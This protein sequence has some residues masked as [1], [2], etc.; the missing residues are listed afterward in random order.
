[1]NILITSLVYWPDSTGNGPIVTDL[2]RW[3][4]TRGHK[5]T[6]VCSFPHYGRDEIPSEYRGRLTMRDEESGVR[7]IRVYSGSARSDSRLSKVLS[8]TIFTLSVILGGIRAGAA[9]VILAPSPPLSVGISAWALRL[10]KRAPFIYVVQDLFPEAYINL[11]ALKSPTAINFFKAMARFVYRGAAKIVC[12]MDSMVQ[13]VTRYGIPADKVETISNWAD[14]SEIQPC[15]RDNQFAQ[16]HN[17]DG[18]FVVQYAGNI[19]QSQR[20]DL[21]LDC[22]EQ[23][24]DENIKFVIIGSG[25]AKRIL[26][27]SIKEKQL[28]NVLLLDTQPR[29]RLSEVLGACD[30]ALVPLTAGMSNT[31]FPS[32]IYTIMASGRPMIASL[33]SDSSPREFVEECGCGMTIDPDDKGQLL[34]A[35]R[36]L[37]CDPKKRRKMAE[38]ARR[39]LEKQNLRQQSLEGYERIL[40]QVGRR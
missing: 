29:Q 1:M 20:L 26:A 6:V 17:L 14:P 32:K 27:E 12:I 33:D 7:I 15:L 23:M 8:Y 9:D 38:N 24:A 35:I 3:L 2:A 28:T 13:T 5:V 25:A 21:V 22:A 40:Q 4:V 19:G 31:S 18:Q 39:N 16:E 37:M 11:R 10:I 36:V 30:V 34:A